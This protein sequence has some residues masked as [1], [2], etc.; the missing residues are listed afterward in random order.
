VNECVWSIGGMVLT[1]ENWSTGS[2]TI[3]SVGGRWM[4][5][6][7]VLVEWYW[8]GKTEV[9]GDKHYIVWVVGEWMGMEH[10]CNDTDRGNLKC[11]GEK[12]SQCTAVYHQLSIYQPVI[13]LGPLGGELKIFI[14]EFGH[15]KFFFLISS[16][17]LRPLQIYMSGVWQIPPLY[18]G[19]RIHPRK[20]FFS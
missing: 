3:Y 8:Q 7:G 6:Y 18:F 1:G 5:G 10:W 20:I 14:H 11:C 9:L 2:E 4:N 17:W 13:E 15:S 12:I 19:L 16:S